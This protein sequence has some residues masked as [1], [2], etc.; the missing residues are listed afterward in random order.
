MSNSSLSSNKGLNELF[1]EMFPDSKIA[2]NY[3]MSP[4]KASYV[5]RF[6]I[7]PYILENLI[8]DL[9][10]TPFTF[11]ST[12]SQ[13]KK[14]YDGHI[15]YYS[16]K[17]KRIVNHY[18]GSLFVGHCDA[19]QLRKHFFEFG[20]NLKWNI[21]YLLHLGMDGPYVNLKFENDLILELENV[22]GKKILNIGTCNLH[23][24]HTAFEKGVK[25]LQLDLDK[26]AQDLHFF[27]NIAQQDARTS[28]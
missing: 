26:F 17:F 13:T 1:R 27:L 19:E 3:Q 12:T 25:C 18:C 11:K 9:E 16:K 15:Q 5:L 10:D 14:Q 24:V 2:S 6:A 21:L 7:K 4:T 28:F 23:P 8:S 22:Y 20:T